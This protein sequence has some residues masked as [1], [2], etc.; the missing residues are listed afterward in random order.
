M[1]LTREKETKKVALAKGDNSISKHIDSPDPEKLS[2][3]GSQSDVAPLVVV[4]CCLA[5][6]GVVFQF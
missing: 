2:G 5:Q 6:H 4:N 3:S 1:T